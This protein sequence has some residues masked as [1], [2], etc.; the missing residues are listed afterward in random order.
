MEALGSY[1][2]PFTI[3]KKVL[4]AFKT[5]AI[6]LVFNAF[7]SKSANVFSDVSPGNCLIVAKTTLP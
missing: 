1:F 4:C 3:S 6:S 5:L 2:S 7:T